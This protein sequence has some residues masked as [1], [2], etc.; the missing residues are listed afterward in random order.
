[1]DLT[2]L[3]IW[4][5]INDEQSEKQQLPMDFIGSNNMT[6]N[7]LGVQKNMNFHDYCFANS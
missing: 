3:G 5:D 6:D 2:E 7:I 4:I 1:M